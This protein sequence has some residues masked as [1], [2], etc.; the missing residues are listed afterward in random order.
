[1]AGFPVGDAGQVAAQ[2]A[3]TATQAAVETA[4]TQAQ[5]AT[6]TTI[7]AT[8]AAE[9]KLTW[10]EKL[11]QW[12]ETKMK[13]S[14]DSTQW[15]RDYAQ[16]EKKFVANFGQKKA[17]FMVH[18]AKIT[19]QFNKFI[20]MVAR[21][22]PLI[23]V[24]LIIIMIFTNALQYAIMF[25]AAG[26]ISILIV[27]HKILSSPGLVLIPHGLFWLVVEFVPFVVY[28][29]VFM[30]LLL[31]ITVICLILTIMNVLLGG[32]LNN[33]MR[34]ENG[35]M[36]WYQI[37]SNQL[38]NMYK[39]GLMCSKPCKSGYYPDF[40]GGY[41]VKTPKNQPDFCPQAEIMRIFSG[42][43]RKDSKFAYVDFN[44]NN[45]TKYRLNMP[46]VREGILKD[47]YM[48]RKKYLDKC[49]DNMRKYD[50]TTLAICSQLDAIEK[51]NLYGMK[52]E[53]VQKLKIVCNQAF[54]MNNQAY[55]FCSA[56]ANTSKDDGEPLIKMLVRYAISLIVFLIIFIIIMKVIYA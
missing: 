5:I 3:D 56:L 16:R 55:P 24:M 54:C 15:L 35:P 4:A 49:S 18:M 34:C 19:V 47:Y 1:M 36:A 33:I 25:M 13:W 23:K 29:V 27:I 42:Y 41:C 11:A 10:A 9:Q 51:H 26:F 30:A 20:A 21:F 8:E 45:N 50:N 40:T 38:G 44:I 37:V 52:P 43:S 48:E 6:D 2:S 53:E 46:N 22:F 14:K 17:Q 39:R 7:A 31:L 28:F 12:L 32:A